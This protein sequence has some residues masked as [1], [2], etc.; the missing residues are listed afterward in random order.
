MKRLALAVVLLVAVFQAA[1]SGGG[2]G[3]LPPPPPV[4]FSNSSLSGQYA[5]TMSGQD[6][7]GNFI[8]RVG[9]F[10]ADG[11]GHITGGIEDV[12]VAG[13]GG[14]TLTFNPNTSYSISSD[15]R[16]TISLTNSTTGSNPLI[17]S[18]TLVSATQ[19]FIVQ[20]DGNATTSGTFTLQNTNAFTLASLSNS[21]VF[22]FSGVSPDST[23]PGSFLPDSLVGQFI[24]SSG[25]MQG[26]VL[27]ENFAAQL[28]GPSTIAATNGITFDSAN[29]QFGRGTLNFT[30]NFG[31]G[32]V[33][34]SYV[35]YVIDG[36]RLHLIEVNSGSL[37]VGDAIRQTAAPANNAGFTGSFAYL[38]AGGSNSGPDTRVGRFTADGNGGLTGIAQDENNDSHTF[39]VPNGTLSATTYAVDQNF[40]GSGRVTITFT[41]SNLSKNGAYSF[42]AYMASGTQG[43]IQDVENGFI[44]DGQILAQT[45]GPF[46]SATV[47]GD[48]AFNYS[49]LGVNNTTN[50]SG[51][52]DF[53]GHLKVTS[54]TSTNASG[55][56]D[57]NAFSSNTGVFPNVSVNGNFT[58]GGDG[59]TSTGT[60]STLSLT[61]GNSPSTTYPFIAYVV[62]PTT[63]FILCTDKDHI[64]AGTMIKQTP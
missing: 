62:N 54:A 59:T 55:A 16:G 4:G 45:G 60:R 38:L 9:V 13:S 25:A 14:Q 50:A 58:I 28:S 6:P 18:V 2:N 17:F 19:G 63:V 56:M 33:P 47:A 61:T 44:L 42:I 10:A 27:D 34:I 3:T 57:F 24:L 21:Y 51:E 23:N 64:D 12:Q 30:A 11:Q 40:P 48:Y 1:C 22:D 8:A 43:V 37:T 26:G 15:G 5:F 53:V 41:D 32:S 52:E 35:F 7:N 20:T 29:A 39:A 31:T 49:G 36:S 46:S